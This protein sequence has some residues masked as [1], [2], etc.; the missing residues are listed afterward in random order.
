[1]SHRPF[2]AIIALIFLLLPLVGQSDVTPYIPDAHTLHLWH[3]DEAGPPF[4]DAGLSP[5]PLLGLLN[6]AEAGLPSLPHLGSSISFDHDAGGRPGSPEFKGAILIASPQLHAGRRDNAPRSL[7]YFGHDGAFTYEALVKFDKLPDET[8]QSGFTILSMDDETNCR[9]FSLRLDRQSILTFAPLPDSGSQGGAVAHLPKDGDHAINT[10]DWFHV[11]IAYNGIENLSNNIQIYWTRVKPNTRRANRIGSGTLTSDFNGRLGDFAI[12]NEARQSDPK[13]AE[14]QPFPGRIDEV[15]ISSIARNP[16][17]FI[18]IPAADRLPSST[19]ENAHTPFPGV[20]ELPLFLANIL[21]D[22]SP[23]DFRHKAG[24]E[25][26]LEPGLH[27]LD[28]DFSYPT[29]PLNE[30]VQFRCQLEGIDERWIDSTRGMTILCQVRDDQNNIISEARFDAVGT[31]K[32]WGNS[33]GESELTAR[34]EPLFIPPAG[35]HV[36]IAIESGSPDTTGTLIIDNLDISLPGKDPISLW[37][38]G[39]FS[40]GIDLDLPQGIPNRWSRRGSDPTIAQVTS[41]GSKFALMLADGDQTHFATWACRQ[42]FDP[43]I[44]GGRTV[45]ISWDEAYNIIG[46]SLHRATYVNV[47]PGR[48][49]FRAIGLSAGERPTTASL[50]LPINIRLPYWQRPWFPPAVTA[51][52]VA[53]LAIYFIRAARRRARRRLRELAFQNALERDR[54]RIARD[55]HDD[56]GTRITV[57]N[58]SAS[59]AL[60]E[61]DQNPES[62]RR[63]LGKLNQSARDLVV[64]MDDLVWAVDPAHDSLDQ[65]ASHLTRLSEEI[66]RDSPVRCRLDIPSI[67]PARELGSDFRHQLSLAVKEALH[68]VLRHAGPCEVHLSLRYDG[69][70]I[71][72]EIRD[73]GVGFESKSESSR[74][75]LEYLSKRLHEIGGTCIIN[76]IPDG[77][78][79][80]VFDCPLQDRSNL[81]K[82]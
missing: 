44:F 54:T 82:P 40:R 2:I 26:T 35:R 68:N 70:R 60:R 71:L 31:S 77:G 45:I 23:A 25:L 80:V 47:P 28:F 69:S 53:L 73:N 14:S 66:F 64:A 5:T 61:L 75:G 49:H 36:Y 3:L 63:H 50:S 4:T 8:K 62:S 76:S 33:P 20:D 57:L 79:Q 39:D 65:L 32:G 72:I 52:C 29:G 18:F 81:T 16:S 15:R 7:R 24:E 21:V 59:L 12:G 58:L 30:A 1:M 67:L 22:G 56:L 11:A 48:Y 10:E 46:G 19:V 37:Q 41:E 13:N 42:S 27:R 17:D 55:M 6:G 38:N 51:S 78:T 43:V 9:I 34:S 74:H